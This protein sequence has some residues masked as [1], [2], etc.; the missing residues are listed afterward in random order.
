MKM[1]N[2]EMIKNKEAIENIQMKESQYFSRT[3]NKLLK[4]RIKIMYAMSKNLAELEEKLKAYNDTLQKIISEYR[5]LIAEKEAIEKEAALAEKEGRAPQD[6]KV[7]IRDGCDFSE[8]IAKIQELQELE[9][10]V[11]IHTISCELFDGIDLDSYEVQPLTFMLT[12]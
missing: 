4:G 1:T 2:F 12:D 5:D 10:D 9:A 7:I 11:D 3:G 6:V 8:Y